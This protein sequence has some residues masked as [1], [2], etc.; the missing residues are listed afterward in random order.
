VPRRLRA[1]RGALAL[2]HGLPHGLR[3]V[4]AR[5]VPTAAL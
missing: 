5:E 2:P 4:G 3:R 1:R